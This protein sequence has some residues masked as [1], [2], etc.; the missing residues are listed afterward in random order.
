MS[1]LVSGAVL[2]A[3]I[4]MGSPRI[5]YGQAQDY[6]CDYARK[7]E[8]TTSGCQNTEIGSAYLVLPH[9][10]SLIAVT[11]RAEGIAEYRRLEG[12]IPKG[13]LLLS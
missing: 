4:V 10:D 5:I 12:A 6:R 7:I 2:S 11:I 9:I 13:A 8:C 3:V 1:R